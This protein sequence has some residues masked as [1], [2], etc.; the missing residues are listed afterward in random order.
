MCRCRFRDRGS[1]CPQSSPSSGPLDSHNLTTKSHMKFGDR[2]P[3]TPTTRR[4]TTRTPP[5]SRSPTSRRCRR[6]VHLSLY[7]LA[8]T[9]RR[10]PPPTKS[11]SFKRCNHNPNPTPFLPTHRSP[12]STSPGR[13]PPPTRAPPAASA[14]EQGSQGRLRPSQSR[15]RAITSRRGFEHDQGVEMGVKCLRV[16][17]ILGLIRLSEAFGGRDLGMR[18][19]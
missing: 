4:T 11:S 10:P 12:S 7:M 8:R 13:G 15:P 9:K 6:Y 18:R 1:G 3:T 19:R 2:S 16:C 17:V 14:P 5:R